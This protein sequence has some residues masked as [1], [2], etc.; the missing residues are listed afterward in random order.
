MRVQGTQDRI[1]SW[2]GAIGGFAGL[3]QALLALVPPYTAKSEGQAE[4]KL[5]SVVAPLEL[6]SSTE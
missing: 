6:G 4:D 5:S 2:L 3:V 1:F